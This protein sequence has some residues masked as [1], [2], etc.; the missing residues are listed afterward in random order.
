MIRIH[1]SFAR[2]LQRLERRW[3]VSRPGPVLILVIALLVLMAL[4]GT[5]YISTTRIDRYNAR[6]NTA[7]VQIDML[8]DGV[9]DLAVG[10][11]KNDLYN[12][13]KYRPTL[14]S[15]AQNPYENWDSILPTMLSANIDAF[16]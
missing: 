7:N 4:M 15:S 8:V 1:K 9:V 3:R 11:I 2:M 12:D 16:S 5:A 10:Q 6:Q 13:G 14:S